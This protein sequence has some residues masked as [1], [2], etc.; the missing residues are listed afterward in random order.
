MCIAIILSNTEDYRLLLFVKFTLSKKWY[1]LDDICVLVTH[2]SL[3]ITQNLRSSVESVSSVCH[4]KFFTKTQFCINPVGK[5]KVPSWKN[6][7]SQ[8]EN[9]FFSVGK[10]KFRSRA[11]GNTVLG[12]FL[13]Y[14][15]WFL[16]ILTPICN[17]GKKVKMFDIERWAVRN[18]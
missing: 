10:S 2:C 15:I 14:F 7:I 11:F 5:S 17:F 16:F 3:L 12:L 1:V 18:E 4:W 9:Y 13:N 8:Q 6:I